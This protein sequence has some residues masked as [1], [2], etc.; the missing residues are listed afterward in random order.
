MQQYLAAL[1]IILLVGMV[2]ARALM[3]NRKGIRAINFANLDK[4]DFLIP[5][6]ALFYFYMIFA[7]AFH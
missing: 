7:N 2:L 3:M 1:T 5:P 4:K 6:F